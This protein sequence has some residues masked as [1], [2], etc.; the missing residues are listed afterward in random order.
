MIKLSIIIVTHNTQK[1][2]SQCLES[3]QSSKLN[4]FKDSIE[5]IVI[6]NAS[7]DNTA[8]TIIKEFPEVNIIKNKHNLGY[9]QGNNQGMKV[10]KGEWVLL[11]NSDTLLH[12]ESLSNIMKYISGTAQPNAIGCKIYNR[13][14]K[15]EKSA[16]YLPTLWNIFLWMFFIDDIPYIKQLVKAYH[17]NDESF[18][19]RKHNVGWIT[20]AF[21][22]IRQNIVKKAGYLDEKIFMYGEEIEWL[23]RI[24]KSGYEVIYAPSI[25]ITHLKGQSGK[26]SVAGIVEEFQSLLYIFDKHFPPWQK[27]VLHILLKS[28]ALL[29]ICI[30]GILLGDK[31]RF[32]IY[33]KAF[34]MA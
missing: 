3:I 29:R 5:I 14:G 30:F 2:T 17:I 4:N 9:A 20:G 1:I 27:P 24:N 34:S 32:H 10:A 21:I 23:L 28:G 15:I 16:G 11:L 26:G 22:L 31:T 13:E 18:Y 25:E 33:A 7:V 8:Q 19:E 6:D 12:P